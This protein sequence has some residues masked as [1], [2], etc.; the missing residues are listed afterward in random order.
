MWVKQDK[1]SA[2]MGC[3]FSGKE[4]TRT[5]QGTE[6][7]GEIGTCPEGQYNLGMSYSLF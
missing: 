5:C 4:W 2:K 7:V 6:W 3:Q 1:T